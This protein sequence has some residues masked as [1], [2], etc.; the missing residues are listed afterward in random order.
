M[1]NKLSAI[2]ISKYY[3]KKIVLQDISLHLSQGEIVGLFG[4]NGAGKTTCFNTI[5]GLTNPDKGQIMFNDT[6]ITRLP[7]H[8]RAKMGICYLPQE[9]SIFRGLSV[10]DNLKAVLELVYKNN[11]DVEERAEQLL[12]KFSITHLKHSSALNL[13]GGERRRL[14][15][16]RALAVNP[17][18][19][20]L[21]EP[22]AG[23]DPLTINEI[24]DML[25]HLKDNF[26]IG[27]LVTDH[28]VRDA[29]DMIDRGYVV[30]DGKILIEGSKSD[31]INHEK[32]RQVYLGE[33]FEQE[34]INQ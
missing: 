21:D 3:N 24:K 9:P 23:I 19:I 31:I 1:N 2:H 22:L 18:F 7:I 16:A 17:K 28:N 26:N 25:I 32:V 5:I 27:L 15:I 10:Y 33:Y 11:K 30:Y 8:I 20:M 12:S 29:L 14:E 34:Q 6:D 13:S 4:P